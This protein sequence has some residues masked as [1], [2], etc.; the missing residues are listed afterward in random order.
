MKKN[1]FLVSFFRFYFKRMLARNFYAIYS[2]GEN[3]VIRKL[4][5]NKDKPFLFILNHSNWWDGVLIPYLDLTFLK[6][7]GYCLMEKKQID[8]NQFFKKIG[9]IEIL[10]ESPFDAIRSLNSCVELLKNRKSILY[11][12]PQGEIK[13]NGFGKNNFRFE[14]GYEYIIKKTGKVILINCL[15]NYKFIKEQRPEIFLNFFEIQ[16]VD[17]DFTGDDFIAIEEEKFRTEQKIFE[18]KFDTN[19]LKD[20]REILSGRK[21][22]DKR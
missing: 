9:A 18:E 5:D 12:F 4:S 2:K 8:K 17:G 16:D 22:I 1:K 7:N 11:I 21:S 15:V 20:Y 19:S 6:T 13:E 14:R 3:E 10:R